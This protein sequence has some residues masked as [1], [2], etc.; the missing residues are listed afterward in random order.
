VRRGP[1]SDAQLALLAQRARDA[2]LE[3]RLALAVV[4]G[5]LEWVI[6]TGTGF[7]LGGPLADPF[8]DAVH[9]SYESI[10]PGLDAWEASW[11][12]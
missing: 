4:D 2:Y 7:L 8:W 1:L 9:A 5:R 10:W 6:G 11:A 3:E 12:A